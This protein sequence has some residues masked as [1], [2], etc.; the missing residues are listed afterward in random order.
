[1]AKY[2][3]FLILNQIYYHNNF[4]AHRIWRRRSDC[5]DSR[6][7]WFFL[8]DFGFTVHHTNNPIGL[9]SRGFHGWH[10]FQ[11]SWPQMIVFTKQLRKFNSPLLQLNMQVASEGVDYLAYFPVKSRYW[12]T[13]TFSLF[14]IEKRITRAEM[15]IKWGS[16]QTIQKTK[17]NRLMEMEKRQKKN[18]V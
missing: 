13:E 14:L 15:I 4:W 11:K 8:L 18:K 1:M 5:F 3:A 7:R 17:Y 9:R 16:F 12:R 6:T 2:P 10:S